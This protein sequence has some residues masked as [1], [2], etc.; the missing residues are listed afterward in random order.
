MV[1]RWCE[2]VSSGPEVLSLSGLQGR[3]LGP[4]RATRKHSMKVIRRVPFI[5]KVCEWP[6][7]NRGTATRI[8][9]TLGVCTVFIAVGTSGL[10]E[11]GGN[12]RHNPLAGQLFHQPVQEIGIHPLQRQSAGPQLAAQRRSARLA[13][14]SCAERWYG[15]GFRRKGKWSIHSRV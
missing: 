11:P 12:D 9:R 10:V 5:T 3:N 1:I 15:R 8:L 6:V 4:S 13:V 14:L 7:Q 2:R